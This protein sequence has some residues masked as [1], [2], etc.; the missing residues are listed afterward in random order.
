LSG[1]CELTKYAPHKYV[2]YIDEK[3]R[4]QYRPSLCW[5]RM[6]NGVIVANGRDMPREGGLYP[7]LEVIEGDTIYDAWIAEMEKFV[8]HPNYAIEEIGDNWVLATRNDGV[9]FKIIHWL[10]KTV[11]VE[12]SGYPEGAKLDEFLALIVARMA[13]H[14]PGYFKEDTDKKIARAA[15]VVIDAIGELYMEFG[16]INIEKLQ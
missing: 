1:E 6:E 14:K 16:L 11:L 15:D 8:L 4:V 12:L 10:S 5:A 7:P 13:E 2:P 9:R 3:G